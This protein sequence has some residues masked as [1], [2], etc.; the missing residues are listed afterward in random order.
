MIESI[1]VRGFKQIDEATFKLGGS[2]IVL[3]GPNNTGKTTVLQAVAAWDLA[4]RTWKELNDYQRHGGSYTKAPIARPSF[5]AVPVRSFDLLWRNRK[6]WQSSTMTVAIRAVAGWNLTMEFVGDTTE[7][8]Y[9]RPSKAHDPGIVRAAK[10][11]SVLVPAMTGLAKEERLFGNAASVDDLLGQG[12]PG[13]VLRNLLVEASR[14]QDTWESLVESIRRLFGFELKPPAVGATIVAE[15]SAPGSERP[16]D[17]ASAGSGF[18]QV[19]MLLTFLHARPG[20]VLLL[21]EPDAHLHVILQD[22]IY[23]ELRRV[24]AE[25]ESQLIV[26]THSEVIINAVEPRDLWLMGPT[27]RPLASNEERARLITSLGALT[28]QEV[29]QAQDAPGILYT[30]G[31]TDLDILRAW[32]MV[33]G[34]PSLPL[35][36][37]SLFWRP[38]VSSERFL[39]SGIGANNHFDCLKLV[40]ADMR[41]LWL[42]DRDGNASVPETSITATGLQKVRWK[43]YEIESY[44]V[45]P[46]ALARFCAEQAGGGAIGDQHA[47]DVIAWFNDNLAPAVV[48]DPLGDH[49][50]LDAMKARE[51][52]LPPA[53]SAGGLPGFHYTDYQLIAASMRPD[54][55]HPEVVQKLD[56]ICKAFGQ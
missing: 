8:I 12:R 51:R 14:S 32:A 10:L 56:A 5:S 24:A 45:H 2:H 48:R 25:R 52:I 35:L 16:F 23:S 28:N 22:A 26:A 33:L 15:Y 34:H 50:S 13:D 39:G 27:P 54:E 21:D 38:Q 36:T 29:L 40:R 19:L 41:G 55:I 4:L 17:I 43:R 6:Y 37:T 47:A 30:E 31:H 7:Q 20:S 9:V 46:A 18:Q 42:L 3:A 1:H 49:E 11:S 44:L 53:L